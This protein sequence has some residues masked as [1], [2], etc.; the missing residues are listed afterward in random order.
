MAGAAVVE[1]DDSVTLR[2][3]IDE[4]VAEV[5]AAQVDAHDEQEGRGAGSGAGL[6]H[7]EG[8]LDVAVT[9]CLQGHD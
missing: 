7:P 4:M 9:Y 6:A 8:D 1:G 5:I 3:P 2:Q